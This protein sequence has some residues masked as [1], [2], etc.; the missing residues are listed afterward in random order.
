MEWI[1]YLL[2]QVPK[3]TLGKTS[4]LRKIALSY[5]SG[6]SHL[7]L[8]FMINWLVS[9]FA[10][11]NCPF[12]FSRT[13][14]QGE[15]GWSALR[16]LFLKYWFCVKGKSFLILWISKA[17]SLGQ[18]FYF[19]LLAWGHSGKDTCEFISW[20]IVF[21]QQSWELYMPSCERTKQARVDRVRLLPYVCCSF[22]TSVDHFLYTIYWLWV[23]WSI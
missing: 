1:L 4:S 13:V 12:H 7:F 21:W 10:S 18:A 16:Q 23:S 6:W 19:V 22:S 11:V 2:C 17:L 15:L 5:L 3:A 9:P 20:N 8:D 14:L